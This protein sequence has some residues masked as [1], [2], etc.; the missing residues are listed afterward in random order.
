MSRLGALQEKLGTKEIDQLIQRLID[1]GWNDSEIYRYCRWTEEA[2]PEVSEEIALSRMRL[3]A[4]A[5][6]ERLGRKTVQHP[7]QDG[8]SAPAPH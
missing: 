8:N 5:V 6:K 4:D 2:N 7:W 1:D 3:V